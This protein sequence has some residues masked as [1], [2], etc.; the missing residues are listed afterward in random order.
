[1]FVPSDLPWLPRP[2]ADFRDRLK[3]AVAL[4]RPS[5]ELQRLAGHALDGN[6]AHAL[7]RALGRLRAA[8]GGLA[9]L[10]P[11]TLGVLSN[12]TTDL[13]VPALVTA[14]LRHG[15]LIDVVAG[16]FDQVFQGANDPDSAVNRR[17]PDLVLLALDHR[18]VS[19]VDGDPSS[20][21]SALDYIDAVRAGIQAGCG[22]PVVIQTLARPPEPLFGSLDARQPG[23]LHAL[24]AAFNHGLLQRLDGGT[25]YL[26]DAAALAETVGLAAWHD[27]GQWFMA[28]LPF[29]QALVPLYA[30]H[31][32]RLVA[33]VRGKARKCL[34]LDL[35]NTLWGG[36]I[37]DDGLDGILIG[38][39]DA[40]GEAHLAVQRLALALRKRG[41]VLAVSSK[42]EDAIA[43]GPF[44]EHPDMLL[45]EEHLAVFQANWTDKASNLEAIARTLDIGLDSLVLLDDNPAERAQVRAALPMVAVPELPADPAQFARIL[46]WAGYFEA[47]TFSEEDR[48]RAEQ[49]RANA[50]RAQL[51]HTV[52]DGDY[53]DS[54]G[55]V[56]TFARFDS[57]G[58]TRIAQLINKSNQFNLTSRRYTEAEVAALMADPT[59]YT[60][61]ARLA[62]RFGD[63][64]M[65][66]VVIARPAGEDW[67]IDTWLMSCRVLGRKV[68][69][70]MRDEMAQTARKAG[71]RGLIG[72]FIPS[73]RNEMVREHYA[74]LGF[75][76][77]G[78][79]E[80]AT[81]WRL[82]LAKWSEGPLPMTVVRGVE[83]ASP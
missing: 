58:G 54:L 73:G 46:S 29:S 35:D 28:K 21:G 52:R 13:I 72:R 77:L 79:D 22:A 74:K 82:D 31:V 18:G 16:D 26:L 43:R 55:M 64:G 68:E 11:V 63:S 45:R 8:G 65:I 36:V 78:E 12:S 71:A 20:V 25:D 40:V 42:N 75:A 17:R 61:Q 3:A 6:H 66:G 81:L 67:E 56:V 38:Q 1:M 83:G 24:V 27:P 57:R 7:A 39:G 19:L 70:A 32:A 47:V 14:G 53:L 69:N 10:A 37:G 51:K 34:V 2:P 4:P 59:V 76:P 9:G 49:Y 50:E 5:A 62:D 23:T 41:I 44:R 60:L 33:A 80:G 48:A 30:E 15:L